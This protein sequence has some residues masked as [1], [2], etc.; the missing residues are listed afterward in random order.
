MAPPSTRR[1]GFSRR[2]QYGLFIGYIVAVGGVLLAVLL[3]II[4][5]VDPRGFSALRGAAL[6]VTAPISGA[7][8][9]AVRFVGNAV[10]G[11]GDYFFAAS[12][13]A[14]MRR[15][16]DATRQKLVEARAIE[17]ENQRLQALLDV[18]QDTAARVATARIVGS[19]FDSSRRLATLSAGSSKGIASGMPVRGP[20]G[21]IG[22]VIETGRFA[23]RILLVSDGSSNIP[24][25]LIRSGIPAIAT[26]RGD[27]TIEIKPL[28]VGK[29]PFRKGDILVTSGTG[30]IFPP[31]IPVAMVVRADRDITVARPLA[32][33]AKIDFALVMRVYQPAADAPIEGSDALADAPVEAP[34]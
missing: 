26:G 6:D 1:P 19:S 16:L 20:E 32:D 22:R 14:A 33:P 31:N 17:A 15:E 28:E 3:M 11:I 23:S 2:A 24:V 5:T 4:A 10:D 13:N 12:K 8:R 7:G 30:G 34:R 21:L 18:T 27:G 29:N 25:Q 9:S